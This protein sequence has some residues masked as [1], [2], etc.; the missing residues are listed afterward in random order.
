VEEPAELGALAL[1]DPCALRLEP[2]LVDPARDRVDLPGE[3]RNP[4][5][6]DHVPV[7]RGHEELHGAT[8]RR[9]EPVEGIDAVRIAELPRE[10]R[11]RHV[12]D[13]VRRARGRGRDVLDLR[14]LREHERGDHEEDHDGPERPGE[15]E[16]RRAVDLRAVRMARAPAAA[17]AD[18]E[19]D[20]EAFDED[21][22]REA[23]DR[24]EE[25]ALVDPL[26]VGRFGRDGGESAVP[27]EGRGGEHGRRDHGAD[28]DEWAG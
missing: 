28:Q 13:E 20:Q 23:E 22:D 24:D 26:G 5:R 12:D 10:L 9:A 19:R 17:V 2:G 11:A 7:R 8:L 6:V 16:P 4:P 27:R 1:E 25:I 14:E 15:L 18:H 21:E 3:R